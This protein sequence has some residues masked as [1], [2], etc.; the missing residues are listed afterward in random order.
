MKILLP[1][2][3]VLGA[4]PG[5]QAAPAA[6]PDLPPREFVY[7]RI[8]DIALKIAVF[9][10]PGATGRKLPAVA[11]FHGGGWSL[12]KLE[13]TFG[14]AR[15]CTAQGWIGIGVQY[16][17]SNQA[18][19]TPL[20]AM[21]DARDAIRWIRL[22]A[23]EL[24]VE[25][26]HV[27][28]L[29]WS[30]GGHLAAMTA[31]LVDPLAEFDASAVPD[32]LVLWFPALS[33]ELDNWIPGLLCGRADRRQISP[34]QYVRPGWPPTIILTGRKDTST[35]VQGAE[36]FHRLMLAAG[37][38]CELHVYETV[39]HSFEDTPGHIDEAVSADSKQRSYDFLRAVGFGPP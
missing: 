11:V 14:D 27:A 32:A 29:G 19:I 20:E 8:G 31:A 16:R 30:A 13:W 23:A 9:T 33:L 7:K 4:T 18:D 34:D 25:P 37:N 17:L 28:A 22:H 38:R 10:P 3:A 6:E 12:G 1:L 24:G 26:K 39:G 21:A 35:P 2:I 36:K 15:R 5:I